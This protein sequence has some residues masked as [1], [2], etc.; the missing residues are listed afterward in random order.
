MASKAFAVVLDDP[1]EKVLER[2]EGKYPNTRCHTDTFFLVPVD[3]TVT[4]DDVAVVAGIKGD[5]RD[6]S[7]IVF[8][9]NAAYSGYTN[10]A[11]WEWL[12]DFENL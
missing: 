12:S 1:N 7:G 5:S 3:K 4:T 9:I 11:L 10:K 8:K 2:L 6:A